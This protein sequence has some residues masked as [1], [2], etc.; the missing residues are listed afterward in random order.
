KRARIYE[1][2]KKVVVDSTGSAYRAIAAVRSGSHGCNPSCFLFDELHV[3][4][5]RELY[6][7]MMTGMGSR[8]QPLMFITTTAGYDRSS[9][10]WE[11]HQRAIK[12][13]ADPDSDPTLLPVIYAADQEDDWTDETTWEKA[14]PNLDISLRRD[15][16]REQC[17]EAK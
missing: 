11:L 5:D 2:T 3:Q 4:R 6:D 14:N 1:S 17:A 16:L 8:S 12:A 10:C 7:V 9:I 13:M 15:Y